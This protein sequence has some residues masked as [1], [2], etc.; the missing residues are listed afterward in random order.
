MKSNIDT[1]IENLINLH[2]PKSSGARQCHLLRESL[3]SL[4][5]LG[6]AEQIMEIKTSVRRLSGLPQLETNETTLSGALAQ[7]QL[8]FEPGGACLPRDGQAES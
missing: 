1:V 8:A 7:G 3:R 5:R 4:V 6:Q 2:A